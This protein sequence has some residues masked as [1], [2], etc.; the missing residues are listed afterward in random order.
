MDSASERQV[1]RDLRG[2]RVALR[3]LEAEVIV[4]M[5][6]GVEVGDDVWRVIADDVSAALL[7]I[8]QADVSACRLSQPR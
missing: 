2:L 7:K 5:S 3:S 4:M 1:L 8:K 6:E